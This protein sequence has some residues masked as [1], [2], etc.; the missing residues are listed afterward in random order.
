MAEVESNHRPLD[1]QTGALIIRP[2]LP[3]TA[4]TKGSA[5]FSLYDLLLSLLLLDVEYTVGIFSHERLVFLVQLLV[6]L[7][8]LYNI[9]PLL[10]IYSYCTIFYHY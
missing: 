2:L 9:L 3:P 6:M 7:Q 10:V 5:F 1:R 8:L 4:T